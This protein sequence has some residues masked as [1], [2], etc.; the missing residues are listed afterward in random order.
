MEMLLRAHTLRCVRG[1][2]GSAKE[3]YAY[4]TLYSL[5][6]ISS[7]IS[8]FIVIIRISTISTGRQIRRILPASS[9][10]CTHAFYIY[11][12]IYIYI[13]R[14]RE[15]FYMCYIY[16][17]VTILVNVCMCIYIYIYI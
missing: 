13:E 14:E 5:S 17:Y 11:T 1:C 15:R 2:S 4:R 7:N 10:T 9:R 8:M 16:I 12:V 6:V 3:Y